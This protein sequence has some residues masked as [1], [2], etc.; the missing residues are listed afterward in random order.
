M[1]R[2]ALLTLCVALVA[3]T[4]P[5]NA[6]SWPMF[7]GNPQRTG[8]AKDETKITKDNVKNLK[9]E[10][11]V[12]LESKGKELNN[13]TVPVIVE[14]VITP[15]GFKEYVFVA[16]ASDQIWAL[17]AENGKIAWT[18]SFQITATPKRTPHWLCPNALNAT[19]AIDPRSRTVYIL[20]S[21]G[22]LHALNANNGEDRFPP[23]QFV[24]EFAKT[25]SLAFLDGWVYTTTSQGC[26]GVKSGLYAMN[27]ADPKKEVVYLQASTAGA[28]IWGRAGAAITTNG[29][30]IGE[31]GDGPY[32]VEAGKFSDTF[33]AGSVKELKL[34]DYYTPANRAYITKKDLD[35]GNMSPV[36]MQ[37]QGKEIVAGSGKEGVIYVLDAASLGGADH[38]TPLFRSPR[39]TNDDVDFASRGF[40][41]AMATMTDAK[42]DAW[43]FAPAWGPKADAAPKFPTT[44]G[45]APNGSIMAFRVATNDGKTSLEP[46]WQSRDLNVPE[47]PIIANGIV[48]ALSNGEYTRQVD[49]NGRIYTSAE[50][51][52]KP[53][54]NAVLYAFD[55]ATGKELY[56]SKNLIKNWTHFSGLAISD[57]RIYVVTNDGTL[58]AFG[59]GLVEE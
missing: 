59:L 4:A 25:W 16:G 34:I 10:W 45:E 19:P 7:G 28:G 52:S 15:R 37:H 49:E 13:L 12:K 26:N 6:A 24:P 5:V 21:D 54:G 2:I 55:A 35:M 9:V 14:G 32:D 43:L 46:V 18:K 23:V 22:K 1:R 30:V 56:S 3:S 57:G 51:A 44:Y 36:V 17:D 33:L 20:A 42:G 58:Y 50:R 40:W 39:Y 47:P 8:W 48:F 41:G 29:K 38:R 31:T 53:T 27:V 11:S